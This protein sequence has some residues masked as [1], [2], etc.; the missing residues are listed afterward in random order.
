MNTKIL[1]TMSLTILFSFL[2]LL[3]IFPSLQINAKSASEEKDTQILSETYQGDKDLPEI[4]VEKNDIGLVMSGIAEE[5]TEEIKTN[6]TPIDIKLE[7]DR[8]YKEKYTTE[9]IDK[10]LTAICIEYDVDKN[11]ILAMIEAES[12]FYIYA[13]SSAKCQGLMQL[14]PKYYSSP[15]GLY[16]AKEN[17]ELGV[18][19][20]AR[21]LS[22]YNNV[23]KALVCYNMGEYGRAQTISSSGYS[24]KIVKLTEEYKNGKEWSIRY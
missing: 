21:L 9:E 16:D 5:I 12:S 7:P 23:E 13:T 14:H 19:T 8:T 20:M 24:R 18:R 11:L 4:S 2:T 15:H 17:I 10:F 22:K 6:I 3:F 1:K